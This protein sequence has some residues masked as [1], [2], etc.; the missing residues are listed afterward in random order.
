MRNLQRGQAIVEFAVVLPLFLFLIFAIFLVGMVMAD[1]LTLSSIARSS[2]RNAAVIQDKSYY[3]NNYKKIRDKYK[4]NKLPVD[5]F[6]WDPQKEE[7]FKIKYDGINQNVTVMINAKINPKG[8]ALAETVYGLAN[9]TN[10]DFNLNITYTM[11]S[12]YTPE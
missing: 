7:N 9:K 4:D 11:Y 5:L 6:Q 2:A 10:S 12:E 1:Y 8:S 3:E